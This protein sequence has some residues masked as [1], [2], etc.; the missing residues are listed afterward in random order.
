MVSR[1]APTRARDSVQTRRHVESSALTA[2]LP[3][4]AVVPV[5]LAALFVVWLPLQL[6]W[7]V[8]FVLFAGGYFVAGVV[9]F[10][11]PVQVRLIAPLLGARRP[12]RDERAALETSWRSVLQANCLPRGRYALAVLQADDL[13]A[14]AC[15]GHLVIVTSYAIETLPR[16]E[17][18]GVLAHELSHHLGFHTVALTVSQWLSMPVLLLARIGFFLQNVATAATDTFAKS[19]TSLTT[20]GRFVSG[21][22]TA[23][24]WVFLAG[25]RHGLRQ[26][27]R[28]RA[29]P[30]ADHDDADQDVA[31][32]ARPEPSAGADPG[33]AHRGAVAAAPGVVDSAPR[34]RVPPRP[35]LRGRG[36]SA[37]GVRGDRPVSRWRC[38]RP[39]RRGGRSVRPGRSPRRAHG[40]RR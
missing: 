8:S 25:G 2:L 14:F 35:R 34:A 10:V 4:V 21:M 39:S 11:R 36:R 22:L 5:W 9:L 20:I 23:V 37:S 18:A 33:G 1:A 12:T 29:A 19:S 6:V 30:G 13:N 17:L 3:A 31:G 32:A 24:S 27:A 16:D 38:R 7:D 40:V 28:Q 15:G 26:A